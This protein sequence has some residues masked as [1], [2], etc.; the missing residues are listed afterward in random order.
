MTTDHRRVDVELAQEVLVDD[1]AGFLH[2]IVERV[3]Q[4]LLEAEM[5]EHIGAATYERSAARAGHRNGHK[6]RAL[7]TRVGA[8]R[9]PCS[10]CQRTV[11]GDTPSVLGACWVPTQPEGAS[12]PRLLSASLPRA[13]CSPTQTYYTTRRPHSGTSRQSQSAVF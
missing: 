9:L 10:M 3:L 8:T 2:R 5:T 13:A 6:T 7:R 4:E 11:R 1:D 12:I